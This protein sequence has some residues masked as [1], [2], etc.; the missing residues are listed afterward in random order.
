M[1]NNKL[2]NTKF[3]LFSSIIAVILLFFIEQVLT[4]PYIYKTL[5][6]ILIFILLPIYFAKNVSNKNITFLPSFQ[7][8]RKDDLKKILSL[9]TFIFSTVLGAYFILW[10]YIDLTHIEIELSKIGV[11]S[12]NFVFIAIYITLVNSFLEEYFFRGYIFT[13]LLNNQKRIQAYLVSSILFAVYHI[14]IFLTWF[15]Y[16]ITAIALIGLFLG[17]MI[18]DWIN[19]KSGNITNSWLIHI[20]ADISI[21]IVGFILFGFI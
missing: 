11:T 20:T 8:F 16:S 2:D 12:I 9:G 13:N 18:F 5:A 14:G 6:K 17:G 10:S 15:S 19:S 1:K 3:I 4:I 21:M 7:N